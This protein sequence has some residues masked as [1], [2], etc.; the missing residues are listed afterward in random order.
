MRADEQLARVIASALG[1]NFSDAFRNKE[2]WIAKRGM[3]GG[4]HRDINEPFQSDYLAAAQAAI[5]AMLPDW[6][7]IETAPR[8]GSLFIAGR[9][10]G[11]KK[12]HDGLIQVD[13]W[14]ARSRGDSYCGLGRFNEQ[15]WPAT[16]WM[17]L[18]VPPAGECG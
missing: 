17:P 2:R 14:H 3:S 6:R 9:F 13:R 8:N 7:P 16:H 18:P 4:R 5:A 11:E 1:D 12:N 15:F 10:T